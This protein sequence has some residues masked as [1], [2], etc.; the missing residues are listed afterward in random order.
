MYEDKYQSCVRLQGEPK[1]SCRE[2]RLVDTIT[3]GGYYQPGRRYE[4]KNKARVAAI[5]KKHKECFPS[6]RISKV[7]EE[8]QVSC[9]SV[10]KILL[11]L[12]D[13][14]HV[15][16]Q[17][18]TANGR[19]NIVCG[20]LRIEHEIFLLALRAEKPARSNQDYVNN[21][22]GDAFGINL[23]ASSISNFFLKRFDY[24]GKFKKANLVR[25]DKFKLENKARYSLRSLLK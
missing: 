18:F 3:A 13:A 4:F 16:D 14:G 21:V 1:D 11:E 15:I 19:E 9:N 12:E 6:M 10:R 8:A 23:S 25:L 20:M 7:A 2:T 5:I 17:D 24:A 22:R